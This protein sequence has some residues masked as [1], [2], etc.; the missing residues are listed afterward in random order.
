MNVDAKSGHAF[1]EHLLY[2]VA[3]A[4][5][6]TPPELC[7]TILEASA[8]GDEVTIIYRQASSAWTFGRRGSLQQFAILFSPELGVES[9]ATIVLRSMVE[10][11]AEPGAREGSSGS[12]S[13]Y[14][15]IAWYGL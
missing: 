4:K 9:L 13:K 1:V 10:P 6:D 15:R 2:L 3:E 7:P 11:H 12:D 5:R 8:Q 14:G